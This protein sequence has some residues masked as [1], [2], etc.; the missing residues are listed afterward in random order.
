[1]V[2]NE[3]YIMKLSRLKTGK[4]EYFGTKAFCILNED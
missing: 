3:R 4:L 1:M 2:H